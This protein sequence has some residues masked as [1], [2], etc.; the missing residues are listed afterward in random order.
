MFMSKKK[1]VVLLMWCG[2]F[3]EKLGTAFREFGEI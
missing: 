3:E 2:R 1:W